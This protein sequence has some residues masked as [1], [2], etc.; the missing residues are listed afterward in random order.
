MS[1]LSSLIMKTPITEAGDVHTLAPWFVQ[2]QIALCY[3]A[4]QRACATILVQLETNVT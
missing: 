1:K 4:V 2:Q 3:H